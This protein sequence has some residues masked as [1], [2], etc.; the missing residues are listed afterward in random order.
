MADLRDHMEK[1]LHLLQE[2]FTKVRTGRANPALVED[3][4]VDYY[5]TPTPLQQLANISAPDA[6]LLLVQ[7]WDQSSLESIEKAILKSELGITPQNDGKIIRIPMPP[8]TEERRKEFVKLVHKHGEDCR[9]AIRNI[10]RHGMD[11]LKKA[12]KDK[13]LGED[14]F[15]RV[16]TQIQ[17]MTDTFVKNVDGLADAKAKELLA[18]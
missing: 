11:G 13:E 8:L 2:D 12:L 10:R 4:K 9:V 1:S 18:I 15:K 16:Q 5:G 6:K 14:D 17:E 7:P 3:L